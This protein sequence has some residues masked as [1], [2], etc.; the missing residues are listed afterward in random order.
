MNVPFAKGTQSKKVDRDE[1]R[2]GHINRPFFKVFKLKLSG[3][4]RMHLVNQYSKS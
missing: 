3:M 2:N 1:R 4:V